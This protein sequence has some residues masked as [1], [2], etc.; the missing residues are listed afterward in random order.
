MPRKPTL[1]VEL[2][3]VFSRDQPRRLSLVI[4]L[5]EAELRQHP[6]PPTPTDEATSLATSQASDTTTHPLGGQPS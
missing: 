6:A 2:E 1:P 4:A 3:F 5:L